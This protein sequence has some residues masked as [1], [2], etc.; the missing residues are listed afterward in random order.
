MLQRFYSNSDWATFKLIDIQEIIAFGTCLLKKCILQVIIFTNGNS[1]IFCLSNYIRVE[2]Y[3]FYYFKSHNIKL[4]SQIEDYKISRIALC[5]D[6]FFHRRLIE[7]VELKDGTIETNVLTKF[8]IC[9][10]VYS[11]DLLT[12]VK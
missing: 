8:I 9:D 7:I 2:T 11:K 3:G 4:W 12:Y 10:K 1:Y 6:V 5:Y